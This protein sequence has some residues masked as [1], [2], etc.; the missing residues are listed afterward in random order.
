MSSVTS[1]TFRIPTLTAR[2]G[3]LYLAFI[4]VGLL[5][6]ALLLVHSTA[7]TYDPWC[8]VIWGREILHGH[9]QLK[10]GPSWK[11]LPVIF[12]T[13]FALF[14]SAAPL[15]WLVVS[16][17]GLVVAVLMMFRVTIRLVHRLTRPSANEGLSGWAA[18]MAGAPA[19]VGGLVAVIGY[20]LSSSLLHLELTGYSEGILTAAALIAIERA[21]DGHPRQ[22]FAIGGIVALDRP[23]V[24]VVWGPFGLWLMWRD[25]QARWLVIA[26]AIGV[27]ALWVLPER[28]GSNSFTSSISRARLPRTYIQQ[29]SCPFCTDVGSY[30]WPRLPGRLRWSAL[31]PLIAVPVWWAWRRRG[32]RRGRAFTSVERAFLAWGGIAAAG[33]GWWLVIAVEAQAGFSGSVRYLLLGTAFMYLSA[34]IG[35]GAA[36]ALGADLVR[37]RI[38]VPDRL[39]PA[40]PL[41]AAIVAALVFA[42][43]PTQ[44]TWLG[45]RLSTVRDEI[46][47][48]DRLQAQLTQEIMQAGGAE[49]LRSCGRIVSE[50]YQV[51]MAAWLLGV[52]INRVKMDPANALKRGLTP[53]ARNGRIPKVVIQDR[54]RAGAKLRPSNGSIAEWARLQHSP[55]T[56]Y[57]GNKVTLY[58]NCG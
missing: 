5:V 20:L 55:Y 11:P 41:G 3:T 12:T 57:S 34:G 32:E 28:L 6:G 40:L 46:Y 45:S 29:Q 43:V 31:F 22:A 17:A 51:P 52:P 54:A 26:I 9:L 13:F 1:T 48:N 38:R 33:A 23:E 19:V 7:L 36:T 49:R 53:P 8:W 42:L 56:V 2:S 21:V 44:P 47:Y 14:G 30:I 18:V 16:R 15:L 4:V 24:A 25:P 50:F 58:V 10:G 35:Y 27:I 37:R 39:I